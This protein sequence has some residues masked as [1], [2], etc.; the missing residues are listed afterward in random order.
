MWR[1]GEVN[2]DAIYLLNRINFKLL[3]GS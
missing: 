3:Y 2:N 1:L